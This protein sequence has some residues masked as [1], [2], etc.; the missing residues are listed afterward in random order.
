M[1]STGTGQ[2]FARKK[3]TPIMALK[4]GAIAIIIIAVVLVVGTAVT[5]GLVFAPKKK[6]D[7]A[8]P[9]VDEDS[10]EMYSRTSQGHSAEATRMLQAAHQ[11]RMQQTGGLPSLKAPELPSLHAPALA[12]DEDPEVIV[13]RP[14]LGIGLSTILALPPPE[15]TNIPSTAPT[16][17]DFSARPVALQ[18][19]PAMNP[20]TPRPPTPPLTPQPTPSLPS[21]TQPVLTFDDAAGKGKV[22]DFIVASYNVRCDKDPS[23]FTWRERR[24]EVVKNVQRSGAS[25][26]CLQEA[27]QGYV[28]EIRARLGSR[29]QSSGCARQRGDEGTQIVFDKSLWMYMDSTT[30]VFTDPG[31]QPC[32]PCSACSLP[33]VFDGDE[34]D[35][36]RI[37]THTTLRHHDN[38]RSV[39]FINTHFPLEEAEQLICAE[40]LARHVHS[41]VPQE[42]AVIICGDFNSHYNC[43]EQNRPMFKL[44]EILDDAH[45]SRDF[46]TYSE[47]FLSSS[48][49]EEKSHRLDFILFGRECGYFELRNSDIV[50]ATYEVPG[51]G[52]CRPSDHEL[53][54]AQFRLQPFRTRT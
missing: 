38:D 48:F 42:E 8:T 16:P 49:E 10:A 24:P 50:H 51:Q 1:V 54:R 22:A 34:C 19:P 9:T 44:L 2:A 28:E 39:H 37:F 30:W 26:L 12:L 3:E 36:V 33:S 14:Q 53:L 41:T 4:K 43:R 35:H 46:P 7:V 45:A 29:W 40:Q 11:I 21:T 23:P 13:M 6:N 5:L 27:R 17:T 18:A 31:A 47:G 20:M 32:P 25:V 52:T 15:P